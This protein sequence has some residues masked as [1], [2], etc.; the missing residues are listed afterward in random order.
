M[1]PKR[2]GI[3]RKFKSGP[4][5]SGKA[6]CD[7]DAG[8]EIIQIAAEEHTEEE[9]VD[10]VECYT[11]DDMVVERGDPL[12][13]DIKVEQGDKS[14]ARRMAIA[15]LFIEVHRAP[16]DTNLWTKPKGIMYK[17]HQSLSLPRQPDIRR[18]LD[19]IM[20]CHRNGTTYK[21][22]QHI[23]P[24][25]GPLGRQALIEETSAD[26]QIIADAIEDGMSISLTT[27][28]V[29]L[30]RQEQE[31][32]AYTKVPIIHVMKKMKPIVTKI[33]TTKQGSKDANS[34]YGRR[35]EKDGD[36]N[37]KVDLSGNGKY[38][39]EQKTV[40]KVKYE[41]EVRL[42]LGC[43][44]VQINGTGVIVG[45]RAEL[46]DY[47]GRIIITIKERNVKRGLEINRVKTLD[48]K[49]LGMWKIDPRLPGNLFLDDSL[50][51]LKKCG[52]ATIAKLSKHGITNIGEL[53]SASQEKLLEITNA[54]TR[55]SFTA[56]NT[57]HLEAQGC[58]DQP[59]PDVIDYGKAD[60]PYL[61]KYGEAL[62]EEKI[63]GCNFMST[64]VCIT[65]MIEHTV[66]ASAAM[67]SK[68]TKHEDDWYF[69]LP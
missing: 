16:P 68:G 8:P 31:L 64:H 7:T 17:I 15:Y 49:V 13:E 19:D 44:I 62:W 23:H 27:M 39:E 47:S 61:A 54:E 58:K 57:L 22:D 21:G 4:T 42:S 18:Y 51:L 33:K 52:N 37:G 11:I 2:H 53:K 60:N 48:G 65:K 10:L 55:L 24:N 36:Q 43:G 25:T 56:L 20:E 50:K 32:P 40:M 46:Y 3:G 45:R 5:N 63:D 1:P 69:L 67:F 35:Q 41:K 14:R 38:N 6:E 26:A 28:L 12:L 34:S 9:V 66:N 29:N 30:H 59:K